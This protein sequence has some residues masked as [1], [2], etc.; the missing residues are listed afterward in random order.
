MPCLALLLQPIARCAFASE[1]AV[2]LTASAQSNRPT[3]DSRPGAGGGRWF[4][5]IDRLYDVDGRCSSA[6]LAVSGGVPAPELRLYDAAGKSYCPD[7]LGPEPQQ[8]PTRK[9]PA[10]RRLETVIQ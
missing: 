5:I 1:G 8:P 3:L 4:V 2:V 9:T 10:D 7:P 6:P